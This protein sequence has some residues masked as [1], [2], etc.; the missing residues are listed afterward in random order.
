MNRKQ[1]IGRVAESIGAVFLKTRRN[2]D[3][4]L[5][6][7]HEWFLSYSRN[8][9]SVCVC[10]GVVLARL[11]GRL[12]RLSDKSSHSTCSLTSRPLSDDVTNPPLLSLVEVHVELLRPSVGRPADWCRSTS[13]LVT[14]CS[15]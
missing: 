14:A 12:D 1:N 2:V 9:A 3:S 11:V 7:N 6:C 5:V 15:S 13:T 4:D 8:S 10:G